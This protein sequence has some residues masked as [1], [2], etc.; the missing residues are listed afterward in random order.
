MAN[1]LTDKSTWGQ[2][3]MTN[4]NPYESTSSEYQPTRYDREVRMWAMFIHLSVLA[5]IFVV[6]LAG[7][8][9]PIVLWQV[10]KDDMPELDVHGR[11]VVNWLLSTLV[12]GAI[13]VALMMSVIGI[14]LGLPLL[15]VLCIA[16]IVFSVIGGIKANSGEVWHYPLTFRFV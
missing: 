10:K 5:G 9:L 14:P 12:Y 2:D 15:L 7:W 8:V 4:S 13:G 16:N 11:I 1:T 6:P 3:S